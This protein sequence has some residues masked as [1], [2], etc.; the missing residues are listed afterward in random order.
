MCLSLGAAAVMVMGIVASLSRMGFVAPL[1]SVMV[2]GVVA[3]RGNGW[4]SAGL[5]G[6]LA[7]GLAVC[8]VLL[9]SDELIA[10]FGQTTNE[11]TAEGRTGLWKESLALVRSYPGVRVRAGGI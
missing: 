1:F 3:W 9:P 6:L 11:M 8:F 5:V 4:R 10:R 7:A 2:M